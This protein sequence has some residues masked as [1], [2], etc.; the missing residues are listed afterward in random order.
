MNSYNQFCSSNSLEVFLL[1]F[2]P[3]LKDCSWDM[4]KGFSASRMDGQEMNIFLFK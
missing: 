4:G 1:H 2:T 3:N